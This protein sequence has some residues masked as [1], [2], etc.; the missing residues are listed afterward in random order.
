MVLLVKK[1]SVM[2]LVNELLTQNS[3]ENDNLGFNVL[4]L[5]VNVLLKASGCF[6]Y[7]VHIF[8][9]QTNRVMIFVIKPMSLQYFLPN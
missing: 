9:K 8:W 3:S 5:E 6:Q 1:H 4:L 7:D 2:L